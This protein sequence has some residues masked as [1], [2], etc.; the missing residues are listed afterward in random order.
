MQAKNGSTIEQETIINIET[1]L[2]F[3]EDLLEALNKT[4]SDQ[5]KQIEQLW[6]ANRTLKQQLEKMHFESDNNQDNNPPPHY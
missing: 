5:Q 2:A 4:V 1:R 3:Q 6:N